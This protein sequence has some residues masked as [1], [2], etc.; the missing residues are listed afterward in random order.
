MNIE[1]SNMDIKEQIK[2]INSKTV[3]GMTVVN[4]AKEIGM[5]DKTL[6][7]N[8][9]AKNYIFDRAKKIYLLLESNE[10]TTKERNN[11]VSKEVIKNDNK[12]IKPNKNTLKTE[13]IPPDLIQELKISLGEIK[14]LLEMKEQIKEV[15]QNYNK[16]IT[17]INE[18]VQ[19]DLKIDKNKLSGELKSRLIKVYDN[20]NVEWI[21]FCKNN[22]QFKMQDLCSVALLEFIEKYSN[23]YTTPEIIAKTRLK[24]DAVITKGESNEKKI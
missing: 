24:K 4:V 6:R 7:K 1:F 15:I 12:S 10:A 19:Q 16:S 20:V 11:L 3:T 23:K 8:L 14:E 22:N 13:P 21:T 17:P 9:K 2:F 5:S 18:K